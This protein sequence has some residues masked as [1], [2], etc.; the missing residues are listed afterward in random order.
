[1]VTRGPQNK[2]MVAKQ[3]VRKGIKRGRTRMK[4]RLLLKVDMLK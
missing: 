3:K 4:R 1:M 2:N